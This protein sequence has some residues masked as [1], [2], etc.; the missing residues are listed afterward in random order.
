MSKTNLYIDFSHLA[1]RNLF[2]ALP[3]IKQ[4]GY[5]VLRH[6]LLRSLLANLRKFEAQRVYVCFD[7]GKSWRKEYSALYKGQ[8][9]EA[10]E[11]Q[12]DIEWDKFFEMMDKL[13]FEFRDN[14]PF[15][16]LGY[17]HLEADDIVA[18][19]IKNSDPEDKNIVVT[20]DGDYIQ[21]MKYPNTKIYDPI[22]SKY[23]ECKNPD[24]ALLMK[25]CTGDKS[26]NIPAIIPRCGEKTAE[27]LILSGKL[28]ILLEEKETDGRTPCEAAKNFK[29]NKK[30]IDLTLTPA[31]LLRG[32]DTYFEN[33]KMSDSK[34]LFKYFMENKLNELMK[35]ISTLRRTFA[36]LLENA[37]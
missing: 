18:Y 36:K 25:I 35:D 32:F 3:L 29:L 28:D 21:L 33:Y 4:Y 31:T 23:I 9:K 12:S 34:N 14:F 5:E 16:V 13:F 1:Y 8:R 26:D 22:K 2:G 30:L 27:K 6:T 11:K 15:Y 20:S 37:G 7:R 10:R 19:M 17:K 24:H